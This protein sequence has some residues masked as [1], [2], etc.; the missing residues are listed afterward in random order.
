VSLFSEDRI[1]SGITKLQKARKTS[2]QGRLDGFFKVVSTTPNATNKRKNDSKK[3]KGPAAKKAK[4]G[5][6]GKRR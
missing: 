4:A 2:V 3:T 6:F 5:S 1:R